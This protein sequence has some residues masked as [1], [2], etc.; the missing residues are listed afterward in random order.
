MSNLGEFLKIISE[1]KKD[2]SANDPKGKVIAEV[3]EHVKSDLSELFSQLATIQKKVEVLPEETEGKEEAQ[4]ILAEVILEP[5]KEEETVDITDINKY[6]TGKS[7][8]QP[9]PEAPSRDVEDIRNKIKYLEQWLGKIAAHGPGS[10][11]VRL[12]FLDDVNRNSAKQDGKYLKYDAA[13]KKWIGDTIETGDVVYNTTL[14]ETSTYT[15]Q[16]GDWYIGVNYAGAVTITMPSSA[17]AGRVV[18]IKDESGNASTNPI[19][20]SG[21]IDNDSG[22]FILQLDNGGVQMVYRSGWR[23]I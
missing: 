12:E 6:L 21:T 13:S 7:F 8:Q 14:V 5:V 16:D 1:G 9:N 4:K 20:V 11:E 23:I 22:G 3:K 17:T 10:G 15:V 18:V 19:T 2:Y